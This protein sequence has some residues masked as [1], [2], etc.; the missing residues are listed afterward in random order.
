MYCTPTKYFYEAIYAAIRHSSMRQSLIFYI[1]YSKK[2]LKENLDSDL[3]KV[4]DF[5]DFFYC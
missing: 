1:Q 5:S 2:L 4:R 3:L